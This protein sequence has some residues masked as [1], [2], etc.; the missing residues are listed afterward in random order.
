MWPWQ[1]RSVTAASSCSL[2]LLISISK[3]AILVTSPFFVPSAL[4]TSNEKLIGFVWILLSLTNC[5]SISV[6]V[7]PESTNVLALRFFPFFVLMFAHTFNFFSELLYWLGIIYLFWDF[8]EISYIM[9]TWDF[10]QNPSSYHLFCCLYWL[11]LPELFI[12]S[13]TASLYSSFQCALLC[14][15]WNISLFPPLSSSNI[16]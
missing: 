13:L 3:G 11:I 16:L 1:F 8:T 5:L 6:Y 10:H 7:H 4:K 12:S 9:S 15:I 14:H 2:C